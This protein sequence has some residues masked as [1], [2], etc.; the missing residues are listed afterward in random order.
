MKSDVDKQVIELFGVVTLRNPEACTIA[1][2]RSLDLACLD[3]MKKNRKNRS[4]LIQGS[5]LLRNLLS[6][7]PE[8]ESR[9][10]REG[11]LF[12]I[13]DMKK[14]DNALQIAANQLKLC[15]ASV[16]YCVS[17]NK[18]TTASASLHLHTQRYSTI[19]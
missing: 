1:V 18:H 2:N 16:K 5:F 3:A 9:L 14:K 10:I 11:I 7:C 15:L 4:Y 19:R 13:E 6:K 17:Y 8:C 12:V